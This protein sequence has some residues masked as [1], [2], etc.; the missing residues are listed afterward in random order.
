MPD[1]RYEALDAQ[2]AKEQGRLNAE[3]ELEKAA[4]GYEQSRNCGEVYCPD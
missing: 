3:I 4:T 1:T 2:Y